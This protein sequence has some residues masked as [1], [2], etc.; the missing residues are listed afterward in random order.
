MCVSHAYLLPMDVRKSIQ[1]I[2]TGVMDG[3]KVLCGCW[4]PNLGALWEQV[5]LTA[6]PPLPSHSSRRSWDWT[7]SHARR[8]LYN[9]AVP[10]L[11][12]DVSSMLGLIHGIS[13]MKEWGK[14]RL[15]SCPR[16]LR[17]VKS[18]LEPR[19]SGHIHHED[20]LCAR[21]FR[22]T[23]CHW[24]EKSFKRPWACFSY[25]ES[26]GQPDLWLSFFINFEGVHLTSNFV[27]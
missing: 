3:C 17:K 18:G 15:S 4:E 22:H 2:G 26:G 12:C 27:F 19:S 7:L 25:R 5:L 16:S 21:Y 13:Q 23:L 14:K 11:L 6:E 20:M 1:S 8:A 24:N 10:R 9:P